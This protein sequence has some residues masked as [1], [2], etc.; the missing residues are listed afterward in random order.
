MAGK[1]I[2]AHALLTMLGDWTAGPGASLQVRLADSLRQ[3]IETGVLPAGSVLPA[4]RALARD[5]SVSRSTVTA[6]L[7]VLKAEGTL[8]SRQGSG[9]VVV[10]PPP[11]STPGATVMP[12]I[13]GARRGIDLAASTPADARAL[14][15]VDVD[16]EA[17]LRS[18]PR[19][20]YSPEG[21]PA[22][23]HAVAE[24][25]T[26]QGLPS[27]L[28]EIVITNGAQHALA[29]AL[30]L[31]AQPGD[32]VIVDDPTYPGMIDLLASRRLTPVSLPRTEGRIDVSG[33][34][35]LVAEKSVS[36]A[37][38]QTGV[39]NPT[40][41]A[42]EDWELKDLATACD[43][44]GLTVLE[45]LVLADLRFDGKSVR[46]LAA[47]VSSASVLVIGSISK[48]GWGGLRIGWLRA[49]H[50]LIE[51]LLRARLTEDLGSSVPSQVIA[52]GVLTKFDD[53]V[54]SRQPTL[55][56][57]AALARELL[58]EAVPS[59][60]PVQPEGGLSLWIELPTASAEALSQ[61]A[62]R[63]G[64]TVA[65]GSSA[66]VDGDGA[67]FVRLCFDRPESQLREGI[68]RLAEA[69]EA[70]GSFSP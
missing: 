30:T 59:W 66:I 27:T 3:T 43:E 65:T 55:C 20:G 23:R 37:Y 19:H 28:D 21:L 42:A 7:S 58:A 69:W 49:P 13:L 39:H 50:T 14:P 34:R 25:F 61:Q 8:E 68:R 57:R 6:A 17:L 56:S 35:R 11:L 46:P 63:H 10:G 41:F 48:L 36:I 51:R 12:G 2:G 31:L 47:R 32:A 9:T 54:A 67:R 5:L 52:A 44:L 24:R 26:M 38:L 60:R 62:V 64:V 45:D 1:R 53:V 29:L 70:L 40:G 33:L 18:G 15:V 4:E 22:L 16:L